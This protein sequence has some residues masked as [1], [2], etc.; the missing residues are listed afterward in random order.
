MPTRG[1]QRTTMETPP[2]PNTRSLAQRQRFEPLGGSII[3]TRFRYTRGIS[4]VPGTPGR[5]IV[6]S[7][8]RLTEPLHWISF[9]PSCWEFSASGGSSLASALE[10]LR[11]SFLCEL[12]SRR[13][14]P[15]SRSRFEAIRSRRALGGGSLL[16]GGLTESLPGSHFPAWN[17]CSHPACAELAQSQACWRWVDCWSAAY[18]QPPPAQES[19]LLVIE[20]WPPPE[21]LR[22]LSPALAKTMVSSRY[23]TEAWHLQKPL[24]FRQASLPDWLLARP[25]HRD[26]WP[27]PQQHPREVAPLIPASRDR[28][29]ARRNSPRAMA[30]ATHPM[31]RCQP[32]E[33]RQRA[34]PANFCR[35]TFRLP[36]QPESMPLPPRPHGDGDGEPA[37]LDQPNLHSRQHPALHH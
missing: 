13:E 21:V 5:S 22:R 36:P 16:A 2:C 8:S 26:F 20:S 1:H 29:L 24:F 32:S 28:W 34:T 9:G 27:H 33:I 7:R 17:R 31:P 19:E 15:S 4:S 23:S 12:G 14:L 37:V 25:A 6:I 35:T 10:W 11:G 3:P 30:T 18:E